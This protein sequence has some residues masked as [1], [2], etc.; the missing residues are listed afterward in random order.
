[1]I[2]KFITFVLNNKLIREEINPSLPLLDYI[3][4]DKYLTGT[5]E[6]CKEGDCG[7]C[8][9]LIGE[10]HS[11]SM[12]YKTITSCIYPI[13][14]CTNKHIVTIEGIN[15][16]GLRNHQKAFV[17]QHASQCGFCTPG[18]IMSLT[19]YLINNDQYNIE[20]AINS[21]AGNV[22]R[23]T[24]Y[25]SIERA[26]KS[27]I[28]NIKVEGS[29]DHIKH[30]IDHNI[31]P[32]YFM[33]IRQLLSELDNNGIGN[34][35]KSSIFIGGGSDLFVQRPQDMIESPLD[36]LT[37]KVLNKI[38]YKNKTVRLGSGVTFEDIKQSEVITELF[39]ELSKEID[40]IASL[41][42]RNAATL[43]G[44]IA[45]ASPIG[46][47]TI[48]L[49][50]LNSKLRIKNNT[51]ERLLDLQNFYLG[52]K[53]VDK[54]KNEFIH[55]IEF[56][57]PVNKYFFSFEKVSKRTHLDIASVNTALLI[58]S[59]GNNI[60]SCNISAGGIAPVPKLLSETSKYLSG[61]IISASTIENAL[62]IAQREIAPIDDVRGSEEYKRL[63]LTQLIK[64][65]F[66]KLFPQFLTE[67]E[68]V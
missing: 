8:T 55:S 43:G 52:Y 21:L 26:L 7:A 44:N 22:C 37:S 20:R 46:D 23:C 65:H 40:L 17:D 56:S 68:L 35:N 28:E 33:T 31:I 59:D 29:H 1:M 27:V 13:G 18:F 36:F 38:E 41:P 60:D 49:L 5:K 14:N 58:E 50:A 9:V 57:I 15:S 62:V 42:I 19:A 4:K 12:F 48:I 64:A 66:I 34:E 47:L 32:E 24:G 2:N 16:D 67:G 3:R 30:L 51:K 10:L 25:I 54:K 53:K 45:N 61:K 11:G 6:V 63:L 39:P